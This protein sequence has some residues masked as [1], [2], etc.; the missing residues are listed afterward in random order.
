MTMGWLLVRFREPHV[1]RPQKTVA[2]GPI[3]NFTRSRRTGFIICFSRRSKET[4]ISLLCLDDGGNSVAAP[5][6]YSS[7][8][9]WF[10]F[11]FA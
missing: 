11:W 10:A 6:R 8:I 2:S 7:R 5:T 1:M 4:H 9:F 3:A